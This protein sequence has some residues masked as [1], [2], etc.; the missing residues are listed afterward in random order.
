MAISRLQPPAVDLVAR[1]TEEDKRAGA[2]AIAT[3]VCVVLLSVL[4]AACSSKATSAISTPPGSPSTATAT[5]GLT[6]PPDSVVNADLDTH[7]TG[8]PAII[9]PPRGGQICN[10]GSLS[11]GSEASVEIGPGTEADLKA[12]EAG[13]ESGGGPTAVPVAN[14]GNDAFL[15]EG[16]GTVFVLKGNTLISVSSFSS[17][18][19]QVESLARQIVGP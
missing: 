1:A 7:I 14:L 8:P 15:L 10:Y 5:A 19:A 6:C 18:D 3:V 4:V 16:K 12:A 13:A 11:E 17:T 9:V 2:G